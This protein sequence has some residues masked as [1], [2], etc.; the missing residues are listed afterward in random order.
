MTKPCGC[1]GKCDCVLETCANCGK[2]F[3]LESLCAWANLILRQKP[4][5]SI[6]CLDELKLKGEEK[7]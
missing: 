6:E 2:S 1:K 3:W 5:C 7:E 4:V